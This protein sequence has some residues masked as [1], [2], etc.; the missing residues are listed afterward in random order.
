MFDPPETQRSATRFRSRSERSTIEP[1]T[2]F[3]QVPEKR[4]VVYER[5][6]RSR[7]QANAFRSGFGFRPTRT[8]GLSLGFVAAAGFCGGNEV[9]VKRGT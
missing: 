7:I 4:L 2:R 6:A 9:A 3:L 8:L 5:A 1:G